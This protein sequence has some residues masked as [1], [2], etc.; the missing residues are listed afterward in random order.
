MKRPDLQD[1][2]ITCALCNKKSTEPDYSDFQNNWRWG[3]YRLFQ[4]LGELCWYCV[5]CKDIL[6]D[7]GSPFNRQYS[8]S[9]IVNGPC[10]RSQFEA[11]RTEHLGRLIRLTRMQLADI[12]TEPRTPEAQDGVERSPS[13]EQSTFDGSAS[14]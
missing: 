10:I 8:T 2:Y 9:Q 4:P 5:Q 14:P 11:I 13:K 1:D 6:N 7:G 12:E 3:Q